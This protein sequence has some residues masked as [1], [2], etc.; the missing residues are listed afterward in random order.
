[1]CV[2]IPG[3]VVSI[4]GQM[5]ELDVLGATRHASTLLLPDVKVGEYV[6]VNAGL[7]AQILPEQEA[8]I[9]IALFE[10]LMRLDMWEEGEE[11]AA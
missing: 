3:K 4:T 11:E 1:M 9:T 2:S 6:L 8:L 10:E 7:I 5:A